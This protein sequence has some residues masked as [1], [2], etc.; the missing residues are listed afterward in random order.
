MPIARYVPR[1][2]FPFSG[3][4]VIYGSNKVLIVK[5]DE[6]APIAVIIEDEMIHN[7][8]RMIFELS[9]TQAKQK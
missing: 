2:I 7:M 8:M 6:R 9:W 1:E 4:I 3:E 5:F